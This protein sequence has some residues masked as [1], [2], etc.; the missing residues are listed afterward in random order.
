MSF[1]SISS[2]EDHPLCQRIALIAPSSSSSAAAATTAS[3]AFQLALRHAML[4]SWDK[5]LWVPSINTESI[6]HVNNPS[7]ESYNEYE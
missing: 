5:Y 1:P 3:D 4:S 7:P 2:Q 6:D